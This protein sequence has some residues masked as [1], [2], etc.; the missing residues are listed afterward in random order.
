MVS[1]SGILEQSTRSSLLLSAQM[2]KS[3]VQSAVCF[4]LQSEL[5]LSD[6]GVWDRTKLFSFI[7]TIFQRGN[8]AYMKC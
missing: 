6:F 8:N 7:V 5:F 1:N 2:V 3:I 4:G